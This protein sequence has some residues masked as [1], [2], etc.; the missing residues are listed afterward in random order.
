MGLLLRT[1]IFVPGEQGLGDFQLDDG[2]LALAGIG[3][4]AGREGTGLA[5]ARQSPQGGL[6]EF[7]SLDVFAHLPAGRAQAAQTPGA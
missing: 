1:L 3:P 6:E 2:T 7:Q 5:V 4:D